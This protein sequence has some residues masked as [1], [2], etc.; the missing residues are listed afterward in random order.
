M[1]SLLLEHFGSLSQGEGVMWFGWNLCQCHE[2]FEGTAQINKSEE[3]EK[4][5]KIWK[6]ELS[7]RIRLEMKI[8]LDMKEHGEEKPLVA[9]KTI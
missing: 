6:E 4:K 1:F 3:I 5:E 2:R 8:N 9:Y 7:T